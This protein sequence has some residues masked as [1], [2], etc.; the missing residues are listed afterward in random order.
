MVSVAEG[1]RMLQGGVDRTGFADMADALG[2]PGLDLIRER[3]AA[4]AEAEAI[5][6]YE[7]KQAERDAE[8]RDELDKIIQNRDRDWET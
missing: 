5:A 4:L 3:R 2:N 8:F 6:E 7:R 1:L